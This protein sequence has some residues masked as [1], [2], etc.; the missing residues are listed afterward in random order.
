MTSPII[1]QYVI[2]YGRPFIYTTALPISLICGLNASFDY[3]EGPVGDYV[4]WSDT[5]YGSLTDSYH[6]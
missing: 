5:S 2:N 1:R 3:L 6:S 4:S